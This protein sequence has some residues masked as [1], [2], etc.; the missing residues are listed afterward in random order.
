MSH[1]ALVH[2]NFLLSKVR[3]LFEWVDGDED[4]SDVS[5]DPIIHESLL[6]VFMY[7]GFRNLEIYRTYI[8]F[9]IYSFTMIYFRQENQIILTRPAL[10]VALPVVAGHL[11]AELGAVVESRKLHV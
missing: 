10:L 1:R 9:Y 5:E 6:E 7:F 3:H 11:G 8:D 2:F 4:R